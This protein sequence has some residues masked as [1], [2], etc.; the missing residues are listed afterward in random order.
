MLNQIKNFY[1]LFFRRVKNILI[2][3]ITGL[4]DYNSFLKILLTENKIDLVLLSPIITSIK[5]RRPGNFNI[6]IS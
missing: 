4:R 3:N 2:F 5:N 6:N 1:Y